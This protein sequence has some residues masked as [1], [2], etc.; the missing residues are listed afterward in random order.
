MVW[1]HN[2]YFLRTYQHVCMHMQHAHMCMCMCMCAHV[3]VRTCAC[4]CAHAHVHAHA[5]VTH[6]HMC[7]H[8]HMLCTC[9]CACVRISVVFEKKK[10]CTRGLQCKVRCLTLRQRAEGT[11]NRHVTPLVVSLSVSHSVAASGSATIFN[12]MITDRK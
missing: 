5:H 6:M 3:H 7:M 1:N 10:T 12:K 8:M 2:L 4:A 11:G 9:T